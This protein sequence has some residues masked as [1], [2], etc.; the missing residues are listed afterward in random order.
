M[1]LERL[2]AA[3]SMVKTNYELIIFS[4]WLSLDLFAP[5]LLLKI[6]SLE[7]LLERSPIQPVEHLHY[8]FQHAFPEILFL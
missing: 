4:T 8:L 5:K 7:M 1:L 3:Q 2:T 6:Q